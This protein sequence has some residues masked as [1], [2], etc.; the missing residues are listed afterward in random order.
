M[1][2][3]CGSPSR[4]AAG[5]GVVALALAACTTTPEPAPRGPSGTI[6][7]AY[8]S[9]PPTLDPVGEIAPAA[10]DLLRPVLPSFH[11]VTPDLEYRLSLLAEEP[12]VETRG[13]RMTVRFRIRSDAR[14]SDGSPIT[15]HDVVHTAELMREA[16]RSRRAGFEHLREVKVESSTEGRL[17]LI[18]P[19]GNWRG[20]FSS[21]R[22][23]LPA[24]AGHPG[25]WDRGPPLAGGPFEVARMV[26]GR[27]MILRPNP[28]FFGP[29]PM[30]GRLEITFVPDAT[31]AIQLLREGR[32]D[33][34]APAFGVSWGHRLAAVEEV[35]RAGALGHILAHMVLNVERLPDAGDRR[36]V[37]DAIDRTR[38][39]EAVVREEG[40]PAESVVPPEVPGSIPAWS[41]Y[42]RGPPA[43][44]ELDRELS[45]IYVRGELM[46]LTAR[47]IQAELERVGV[48]L[49]LVPLEYEVF[50]GAFF[51]RE[52]FDLALIESRGG[53]APELA[54]RSGVLRDP[55]LQD[56]LTRTAAGDLGALEDAQRR[57]ASL[58]P[59]VPLFQPRATMGWREGIGGIRPNASADGPLWN[60]WAW[61]EQP[62]VI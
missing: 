42:G 22:F 23:V 14:W 29:R 32:V 59:V 2:P 53:P 3:P 6:R 13:D 11:L 48:D 43:A 44:I 61:S 19:L 40:R 45:M 57:L 20:L 36:S 27:A 56:A 8:P 62:R 54:A 34:V 49:E 60:T 31:T 12:Q 30:A 5:L 10:A 21:G 33:A 35:R 17:V 15:V 28:H 47:F 51:P 16:P 26:P 39:A 7:I 46:E 38:F 37:A 24:A 4:F 18:P 58:A 50:W 41:R 9:E 25:R 1:P 55:A 52:R